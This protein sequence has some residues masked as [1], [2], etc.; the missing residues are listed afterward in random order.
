[1]GSQN[2]GHLEPSCR[3]SF[4]LCCSPTSRI[5]RSG[6]QR[7]YEG[8]R[9][10]GDQRDVS[11]AGDVSHVASI[12]LITYM[13]YPQCLGAFL[14]ASGNV[15]PLY[16]MTTYSTSILSW[17]SSTGSLMLAINNGVNSI[18]R[19]LMGV[20]ADRFGRQNTMVSSVRVFFPIWQQR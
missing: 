4:C 5:W 12:S 18:S 3:P 1:M 20:F 9:E 16:Y 8:Q 14:Q 13:I 10:I 7:I 6:S 15:V 11:T 17:S 2:T 19:I